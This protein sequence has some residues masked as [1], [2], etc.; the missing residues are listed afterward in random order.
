MQVRRNVSSSAPENR[1][2]IAW[3][4]WY[5]P[6][7]VLQVGDWVQKHTE[8]G[9]VKGLAGLQGGASTTIFRTPNWCKETPMFVRQ[10]STLCLLLISAGGLAD[11]GVPTPE[12]IF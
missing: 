5:A 10:L 6:H 9:S 2:T 3:W 1:D 4:R 8:V 12:Y 7:K 11:Q